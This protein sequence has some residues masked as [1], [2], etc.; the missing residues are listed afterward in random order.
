MSLKDTITKNFNEINE[1]IKKY[2]PYPE[3]VKIVGATKYLDKY[4]LED[5]FY[6]G[7]KIIGENRVQS[8]REKKE[9]FDNLDISKKI[10]WHFIGSLQKNKLKYFIDY[11][12]LI[13]SVDR[14]SIAEAIDKEAKKRNKIINCLL[15]INISKEKSKHG[16]FIEDLYEN[17]NKLKSLN[18]L[19]I[20]GLMTMAPFTKDKEIILNVF[21]NLKT[22]KDELNNTH[23]NGELTELSMGMSN[24]Y[25]LAL[26]QGATMIRIGSKLFN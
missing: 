9:H 12:N 17:I 3:K 8:L 19:N 23:F 5:Y 7:A 26:S 15:E 20:I 13:H 6:S 24:D 2:S 4:K 1:D 18:N 21:K 16:F 22:L 14:L 10:E 25:K 11:I